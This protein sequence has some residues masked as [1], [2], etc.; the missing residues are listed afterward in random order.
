MMTKIDFIEHI[1]G[2]IG[3]P[4]RTGKPLKRRGTD[5]AQFIAEGL[6]DS[7][8]I[9]SYAPAVFPRDWYVHDSR[10]QVLLN[11]VVD[12]LMAN[13]DSKHSFVNLRFTEG[14]ELLPGDILLFCL[15]NNPVRNHAAVLIEENTMVHCVVKATVTKCK[16]NNFYLRKLKNVVRIK[17]T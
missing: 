10:N 14:M 13:L 9:T 2:W 1:T 6:K 7:G 17:R 12:T 3:T 11:H 8:L 4:Y 16:L 15:Y 5:C